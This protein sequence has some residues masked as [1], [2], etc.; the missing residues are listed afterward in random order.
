MSSMASVEDGTGN[1]FQS[2]EPIDPDTRR[3]QTAD[4]AAILIDRTPGLIRKDAS[5]ESL[6]LV[7]DPVEDRLGPAFFKQAAGEWQEFENRCLNIGIPATRDAT[8]WAT[9]VDL[10][11]KNGQRLVEFTQQA[12]HFAR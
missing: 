2:P 11:G 12:T 9:R 8:G 4:Q 7:F 10:A 3:K 1:I 5:R 6:R